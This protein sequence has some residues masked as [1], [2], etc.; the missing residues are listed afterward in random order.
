MLLVR[1]LS[2]NRHNL[3]SQYLNNTLDPKTENRASH[4]LSTM[5][6]FQVFLLQLQ[7]NTPLDVIKQV[8]LP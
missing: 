1:T 8:S 2:T 7:P 6:V 5:A 4:L 3:I